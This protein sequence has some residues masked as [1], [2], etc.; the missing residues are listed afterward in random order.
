MSTGELTTFGAPFLSSEEIRDS[1]LKFFRERQHTFVPSSGIAP[2]DDPTILFTNSGMN[3]FKSIFLGDN[4]A[5]LK[6]ATNSQKCLRVSGKHNDLD[7]V[8]RDGTHHTFFEMLG[9]WSFGDYYKKEAISW[10][11]ELLTEVWKLPKNRLYVTVYKDDEEAAELWRTLTDIEPERILYFDKD[12]FWEMGPVGPCGPCSEIHFDLGDPATQKETFAD[13]VLGVNGENQRYIEIWNL[14]FM[15]YERMKDQSLVPLKETHVDTGSGF[16]R[17]CMVI[18]G[19]TSNY[20]TDVFK[21]VIDQIADLSGVA[22]DQ[23]EG[24]VAHRVIADHIRALSFAIADGVTPGNEGRGYVMRRILRR[25][26]RFAHSLGQKE[27]FLYKLISGLVGQMSAAFPELKERESYIIQVIQSE[28]SRFLKTLDQGLAKLSTL[29]G[30]LQ[31]KKKTSISGEDAFLFHD[32]Y[33]F[34]VDLTQIIAEEHGLSVD[35]IG[36]QECM[37]EQRERARKSAK[38]DA[39]FASDESWTIFSDSKE[40]IFT[41]YDSLKETQVKVLRY[42]E[43]GDTVCIVTEKSPFYSESGGQIGDQ[44]LISGQDIQ[45]RVLDTQTI[46]DIHVHRC[47]LIGGL[48]SPEALKI[49]DLDVDQASREKTRR[50]HSATHLLHSAL[51][52][53]LG[54]HVEQQGSW[55]G[56]ER[57]RFDFRHHQAV[58]T[59]ELLE[60]ERIVNE[61]IQSNLLVET[62]LLSFDDAKKQGAMALFGEKYGDEVRVLSMGDFSIELCGGTHASATGDIG[63]FRIVGESSV[64]AGVRRIEARTGAGALESMQNDRSVLKELGALLKS[65]PDTIAEKVGQLVQKSKDSEKELNQF[66]EKELSQKISQYCSQFEIRIGDQTV[67]AGSI[68][69]GVFAKDQLQKVLDTLAAQL[70][71]EAAFLTIVAD[72]QL[73]LLAACAKPL[74]PVMKAGDMIKELGPVAGAKGGGRPDRARAGSGDPSKSAE[75]L[76]AARQWFQNKLTK[77]S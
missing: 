55:V 41:G 4:R 44:G 40:T 29:I 15:Q 66:R 32:T 74:H 37:N 51:R 61:K 22:Y 35:H 8:G 71:N 53:V 23:G 14:V 69:E 73:F 43:E 21:P 19:K 33:G 16:E 50:N 45:L 30:T 58:S 52:A 27:P 9:N 2:F 10:A 76:E 46:L 20:D 17:V 60:I 28:E 5:G 26:C 63:L 56:P 13:P 31:K 1:F 36:Y 59:D 54:E 24:G 48:V 70:K 12:N 25:A 18:Q 34:P 7:E 47:S 67:Y 75:V 57:L 11:W 39:G 72:G 38:F 62:K 64:A 42:R 3:Q 68:P 65:K 49:V 77:K 6:R